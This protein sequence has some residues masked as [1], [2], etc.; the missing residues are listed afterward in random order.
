[1]HHTIECRNPFL[2]TELILYALNIKHE[3]RKNKKILREAYRDLIPFVEMEKKPLR[4][5]QDKEFNIKT[6]E[7]KFYRYY[8]TI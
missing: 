7:E 8:G 4:L 1:M 3:K 2:S 6:I 5:K